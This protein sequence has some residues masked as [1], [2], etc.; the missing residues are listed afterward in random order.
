LDYEKA[1]ENA[2]RLVRACKTVIRQTEGGHAVGHDAVLALHC[3]L[4]LTTP[5]LKRSQLDEEKTELL[6]AC[7]QVLFWYE[8]DSTE[9]NREMAIGAVRKAIAKAEPHA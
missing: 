4:K 8:V 9:F 7:K 5:E 1:K 3:A 2:A 6:D